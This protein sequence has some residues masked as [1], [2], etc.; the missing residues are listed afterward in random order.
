MEKYNFQ[1]TSDE[2]DKRTHVFRIKFV[3][4]WA[5]ILLLHDSKLLSLEA[6]CS[7]QF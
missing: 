7:Q 6:D 3:F 4:S 2:K 1:A 5:K